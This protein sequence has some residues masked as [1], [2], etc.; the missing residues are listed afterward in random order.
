MP[1]ILALLVKVLL[2]L[3]ALALS[4][5]IV[6][7]ASNHPPLFDPPGWRERLPVYLT[8]HVAEISDQARFPELQVQDDARDAVT[9][10][11]NTLRAIENLGWEIIARDDA[12]RRVSAVAT[13]LL[14]K[15]EDEVSIWID[16]R[17]E[18]G[19][20]LYAYSQ[21]RSARGDLGAN[22]RHL[23]DLVAA[24]GTVPVPQTN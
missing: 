2:A 15:L 24:V 16:V 20:R 8:T 9:L 23:Q 21:S 13:T 12:Q 4:L 1:T 6:S 14:W 7:M 11:A 3:P 5:L 17:V 10:Y 18:G 22:A 19:S